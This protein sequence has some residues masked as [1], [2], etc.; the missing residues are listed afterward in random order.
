MKR[1]RHSVL[2]GALAL[3]LLFARVPAATAEDAPASERRTGSPSSR[4]HSRASSHARP[5]RMASR[6]D[7]AASAS[8]SDA[9]SAWVARWRATASR[10]SRRTSLRSR[11]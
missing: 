3:G 1:A 9:V 6:T 4:T 2:P 10:C 8:E 5:P 7:G 11:M